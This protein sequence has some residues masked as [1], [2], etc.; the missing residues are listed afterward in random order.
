[1]PLHAQTEIE[2]SVADRDT[3]VVDTLW[4]DNDSLFL[5]NDTLAW[6]QNVQKAID[7]LLQNDMFKT[8]QVGMLI[9]D[10]DADSVIYRHN[11][12]QLMRPASTMKVITAITALDKLGGGHLFKTDLCYTGRIDSCTLV[13]DVYCVGGFDPRL[14]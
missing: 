1:M 2:E 4:N 8:S 6:P 9:Y 3:L 13:G 7:E 11:E 12:R 5:K 10:L 14:M